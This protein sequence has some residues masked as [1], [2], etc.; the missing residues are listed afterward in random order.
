ML[1]G[2]PADEGNARLGTRGGDAPNDG[3]NTLGDDAPGRDVVRHKE[4]FCAADDDVVDDHANQ[5]EADRVVLVEGLCNGDFGADAIGGGREHGARHPGQRGGIEHPG[6]PAESAEHFGARR[7]THRRLHQLDGLVA[8]LDVDAGQR[9][10]DLLAHG[11][12]G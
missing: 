4:R 6:E 12:Q 10:G 11:A 1:R 7:R 3:G 2:F 9:V 8:C 5:V